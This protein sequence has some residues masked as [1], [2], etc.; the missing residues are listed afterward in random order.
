MNAPKEAKA[1]DPKELA[2]LQSLAASLDTYNGE[3]GA[4]AQAQHHPLAVP[5]AGPSSKKK[6]AVEA[7]ADFSKNILAAKTLVRSIVKA[8][9]E[10][11]VPTQQTKSVGVIDSLVEEYRP[12]YPSLT[13]QMIVDGVE[14]H[15][16]SRG[17]SSE[18][19]DEKEGGDDDEDEE[20]EP[21]EGGGDDDELIFGRCVELIDEAMYEY[22]E[23]VAAVKRRRESAESEPPPPPESKKR[24]KY[25]MSGLPRKPRKKRDDPESLLV[26]EVLK[27]YCKVRATSVRLPNGTF[28]KMV[29]D[30]QKDMGLD[31]LDFAFKSVRKRVMWNFQRSDEREESIKHKAEGNKLIEA[32][33]ERYSRAKLANGGVL[34]KGTIESIYEGIKLESGFGTVPDKLDKTTQVRIQTRFRKEH[35]DVR[36]HHPGVLQIRTLTKEQKKRRQILM[37]EILSRYIKKKEDTGMKKLP[38][39]VMDVIIVETKADLGIHEFEVPKETIRGRLHRKSAMVMTLETGNRFDFIDAPLVVMINNWLS[40]GISVTRAQGLQFANDL[41]KEKREQGFSVDADIVLDA[42]WWKNF[43]E[44]NKKKIVCS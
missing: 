28:E 26:A 13:R 18:D 15:K 8:C 29:E 33:Y 38:D 40:Q 17:K 36:T 42:R 5:R 37:N 24:K 6:S 23:R 41:L 11:K 9:V 4:T 12:K 43:L 39:G 1:R 34:P 16:K 3:Q 35:P 10:E 7:T 2:L 32:L 21:P 14:R 27:R 20:E 44:R 31:D 19:D 22:H 25:T 30:A